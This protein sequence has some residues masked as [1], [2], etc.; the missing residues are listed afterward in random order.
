M[1][2]PAPKQNALLSAR[3]ATL[4]VITFYTLIFVFKNYLNGDLYQDEIHYLTTAVQFSS[5]PI[6]SLHL[7][8]IYEL[9]SVV[10][11]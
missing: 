11:F 7:L 5:Q 4:L 9:E 6:P 1:N 10:R 2:N 8:A 3:Y